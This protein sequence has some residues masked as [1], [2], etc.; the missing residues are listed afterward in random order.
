MWQGRCGGFQI[1]PQGCRDVCGVNRP[2]RIRIG[3]HCS[4]C[5]DDWCSCSINAFA[6]A[7]GLAGKACV[8]LDKL[9]KWISPRGKLDLAV[10]TLGFLLAFGAMNWLRD[11][12]EHGPNADAFF[13]NFWEAA[14]VGI[15]PALLALALIRHLND[16]QKSLEQAAVTDPL[17]GLPNRRSFFEQATSALP[18]PGGI[19]MMLD[20]DHF[21]MVNDN[22]GHGAGDQCLIQIATLLRTHLRSGDVVARLG[23]E[24]FGVLLVGARRED[25]RAIAERLVEGVQLDLEG[26]PA[27][28]V[29]TMSIGATCTAGYDNVAQLLSVADT[30]LYDAKEAGRARVVFAAMNAPKGQHTAISTREVA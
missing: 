7:E 15:L 14:V 19:L 6:L 18:D 11:Q 10:K 9:V 5:G 30:A 17:T 29:V 21:K 28:H 24:E 8:E 26:L 23:G 12:I 27:P 16:L 20:A 25:A 1:F 4:T 13:N 3:A 2:A 22:Y